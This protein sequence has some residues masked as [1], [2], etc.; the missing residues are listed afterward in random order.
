MARD[1]QHFE[2]LVGELVRLSPEERTRLFAEAAR[3]AKA[4]PPKPAFRPP[5]LSGGTAWVGGAL[6]REELYGDDG[7]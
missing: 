6:G 1:P 5:T 4:P 3:R 2:R 7:R